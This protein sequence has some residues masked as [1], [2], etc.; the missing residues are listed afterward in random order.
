LRLCIEIIRV[1]RR[2]GDMK[3]RYEKQFLLL[4]L[5]LFGCLICSQSVAAKRA[6]Q[7][8]TSQD[9]VYKGAFAFPEGDAWA[10]S[11]H[12][13]AYYPGGDASGEA[14]G[15]PGSL[16]AAGSGNDETGDLVGEINIPAPVMTDNFADLPRAS[17]LQSL[18]DITGGWKDNCTYNDECIYRDLDGLA[19]LPEVEKIAWNLNYWYNV[20]AYDQDSLGW[21]DLDM[22]GAQGVWHIGERGI[23]EFHNAKTCDYLFM[24]PEGFADAC[25][26]GRRLIAGNSR[27]AGANGGSQGPTLYA[28]APWEGGTAPDSGQS[29]DALALLYYREKI[30]CVWDWPDINEVPGEGQCDFPDYRAFDHWKGGA[31]VTAGDRSAVLIVGRKGL[32]PNCYGT[33]AECS[34]DP[35]DMYK[36]YH[37]YPY[38]PQMLFYDPNDLLDV[39]TETKDPWTVLPKETYSLAERVF[40]CSCAEPGAAAYDSQRNILYVTEQ[41]AGPYGETAVHVW[42]V[43]GDSV[44]EAATLISPS[45]TISDSSPTYTWN[46]VTD[47]TWYRLYVREGSTGSVHDMW[48]KASSVTSDS[49]C[50]V[51][52]SIALNAGAHTWWVQTFNAY[53]YGPWSSGMGFTVTGGSP[54]EAA[55]LI[56]PSGTISD[57]SP[58]YTWN[59]VTDATWYRLYIREGSTGS[60]HDMWY[61]AS[62]VTSG[63]SCSVTPETSL[64]TGN[65]TWWVRTWNTYGYGPWSTGMEFT[66]SSGTT[67]LIIDHTCTDLD[68]IPESW[69]T[70]IKSNLRLCYGH[71]SHGSQPV[72]G[73]EV[74]MDLNSLYAFHTDGSIQ[75]ETLSLADSTPSGDLGH[76]GD[77]S[78]ADRTRS[79][80]NSSGSDR[81]VVIWSWCGGVSDN[82]PSGIASYLS[83]MNA[84]EGQYPSVTFVYMTGHLDGSGES[85]N[86]H[87]RNNQIRSYC[88]ENNKVLFDFADIE[89]YDPDGEYYL[90]LGADDNCD[91][92]S[93]ANN[94]AKEWCAANPGSVLCTD[95]GYSG[96]CA[97]SQP[98]NCNLKA[99]AF[100]WMLARIAGWSGV[101]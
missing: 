48:Y 53:G 55:T 29:L 19:Y 44:P 98:L 37:A 95:C 31:W 80:L 86:L 4:F 91:Y 89:S 32:G 33:Q 8:L 30:D 90:D 93:G 87:I 51:N 10:Y 73:M 2:E 45:G 9:L 28:V 76:N 84:L 12:A 13:L 3:T 74:L 56:S 14:D 62:S 1:L 59:T 99:R 78:W 64:N 79:Y 85:G 5:L 83:A 17:V 27:E 22:T 26:A 94:W 38:E 58:T 6:T 75:S 101:Y 71:T 35:C 15:Y 69:I 46:A 52:P 77:T 92:N 61:M 50:T 11:G 60:V 36:G 81:N 23:D 82:T 54:P 88:Q 40:D 43:S 68:Q 72:T 25:L 20:G 21:S 67:G 57:L 24:A 70:H 42:Q 7:L 41:Q 63:A 49:I 97:H 65:H 16:Y 96:C 47:A 39:L 66:V 34:G 18:T 100:W